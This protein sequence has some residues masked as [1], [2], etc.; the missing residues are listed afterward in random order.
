M[1]H[2]HT[3]VSVFRAIPGRATARPQ[4][5]FAARSRPRV[6]AESQACVAPDLGTSLACPTRLLL[7]SAAASGA[8]VIPTIWSESR[9]QLLLPHLA[10]KACGASGEQRAER[11]RVDCAAVGAIDGALLG[12]LD[13]GVRVEVVARTVLAAVELHLPCCLA[14]EQLKRVGKVAPQVRVL[15]KAARQVAVAQPHL[16][17]HGPNR[18][19]SRLVLL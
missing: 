8:A 2:E 6:S 17:R 19:S 18:L 10:E 1:D 14:E 16:S 13:T 12:R 11:I 7:L 15:L 3:H 5:G 4:L 9:R